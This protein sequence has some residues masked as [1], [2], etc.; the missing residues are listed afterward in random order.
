MI[1]SIL[2]V[3][4]FL[5]SHPKSD[6]WGKIIPLK[7][8][9]VEIKKQIGEYLWQDTITSVYKKNGDIYYI[10]Y[11]QGSCRERDLPK[12][13]VDKDTVIYFVVYLKNKI[14]IN[15]IRY[16]LKSFEKVTTDLPRSYNYFN[17]EMGLVL[18]TQI[19]GPSKKEFVTSIQVMPKKSDQFLKCQ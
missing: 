10:T 13:N 7:T 1:T 15:K 9:K 2:T 11:S 3:A 12:W 18:G 8:S 14:P 19:I 17:E 16:D 5:F 6:D 4:L